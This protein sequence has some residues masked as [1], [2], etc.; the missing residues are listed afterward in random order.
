MPSFISDTPASLASGDISLSSDWT[1]T[2]SPPT[3][4]GVSSMVSVSLLLGVSRFI[5]DDGGIVFQGGKGTC[6]FEAEFGKG[7]FGSGIRISSKPQG[8]INLTFRL[9]LL[10]KS[11]ILV[12][13]G[14][15]FILSR[16][17]KLMRCISCIVLQACFARE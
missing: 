10:L 1:D 12:V 3:D 16:S 11:S 6:S 14:L 17:E 4:Q 7:K 15:T 2:L 5:P 8:I 9:R 13:K